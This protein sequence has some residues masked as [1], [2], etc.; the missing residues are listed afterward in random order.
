MSSTRRMRVDSLRRS[1]HHLVTG[2]CLRA[3]RWA[4]RAAKPVCFG[5]FLFIVAAPVMAGPHALV[6]IPKPHFTID[7]ASPSIGKPTIG[8]PIT[9]GAIL[10]APGPVVTYAASGL[11]LFHPADELDEMSGNRIDVGVADKFVI[12]FGVDR[13]SVGARGPDPSLLPSRPFNVQDQATRHQAAGDTFMTLDLYTRS[14]GPLP[15]EAF[16]LIATKNNTLVINQGDSGGIDYDLVEDVSPLMDLPPGTPIDEGDGM[17]YEPVPPLLAGGPQWPAVR[18][19]VSGDDGGANRGIAVYLYFTLSRNSPSLAQLPPPGSGANVYVDTDPNTPFTENLYVTAAQLGLVGGPTGDDIDGLMVFDG[20]VQG[21]FDTGIDQVIFSLT[22]NSPSLGITFSAADLFTSNGGGVFNLYARA[23][24]LGLL[25][26]DNVDNLE[27]IKTTDSAA[28]AFNSAIYLVIPGD[29]DGDGV[30]TADDCGQFAGCYTG[31][32]G[33]A[34]LSCG[35]FDQDADGDV[36]CLDWRNNT[37]IFM[38]LNGGAVC[39][40][41]TIPEFVSALLGSP[42]VPAHECMADM[43]LDGKANGADVGPYVKTVLGP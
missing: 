29:Y 21:V 17:Y 1:D 11:R 14:G 39:P 40:P 15:L 43:N 19:A 31:E 28:T 36:D 27:L 20:G 5:A 38:Q 32:G 26:T 24:D 4:S 25:S 37:I 2:H 41:L 35:S 34:T 22:P 13:T 3:E 33:V 6:P 16:R 8:G 7:L 30:L 9:A 42:L 10:D 23:D 12:L 18:D